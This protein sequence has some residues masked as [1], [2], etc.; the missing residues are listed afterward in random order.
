MLS[1]KFLKILEI[2]TFDFGYYLVNESD[3]KKIKDEIKK[4]FIE[5]ELKDE[6]FNPKIYDC[7]FIR[8]NKDKKAISISGDINGKN[9]KNIISSYKNDLSKDEKDNFNSFKR[10]FNLNK[11][12]YRIVLDSCGIGTIRIEF[13]LIKNN[14]IDTIDIIKSAKAAG[15]LVDEYLFPNYFKEKILKILNTIFKEKIK[16]ILEEHHTYPVIATN[17]KQIFS[18]EELYGIVWK[19][20]YYK[21]VKKNVIDKIVNNIAIESSG[22]FIISQPATYMRFSKLDFKEPYFQNRINALEILRRQHHLLK[23]FDFQ[24]S[25]IIEKKEKNNLSLL[26][27]R[28]MQIQD[29][30]FLLSEFYKNIKVTAMQEY[31]Y[32]FKTA[33]EV[34]VINDLYESLKSKIDWSYNIT[35]DL[36]QERRNYIFKGINI[37]GFSIASITFIANIIDP[38]LA[39]IVPYFLA[40]IIFDILLIILFTFISYFI[41]FKNLF[42]RI[43]KINKYFS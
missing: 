14:I 11:I 2:V 43:L 21:E 39:Q 6:E 10:F 36:I 1:N 31:K 24:L 7:E 4:E 17:R 28:V 18:K 12:N 29:N 5:A 34:F 15:K 16:I 20:K 41:I 9:I 23:G 13:N 32:I 35:N 27:K 38:I 25:E 8:V 30:V 40:R 22:S 33:N 3:R 37:A 19:D 26:L 42:N